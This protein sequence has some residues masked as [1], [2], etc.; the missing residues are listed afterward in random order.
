MTTESLK[1]LL[2]NKKC[3]NKNTRVRLIKAWTGAQDCIPGEPF[4]ISDRR[5]TFI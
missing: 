3:C 2:F 5:V 1:L 4:E